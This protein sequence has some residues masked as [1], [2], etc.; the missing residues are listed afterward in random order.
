[1]S[2]YLSRLILDPRSRQVQSELVKP[3]Q[4]HRTLWRAFPNAEA[5]GEG[6][7]R[8]LFRVDQDDRVDL[9][10]VLVQSVRKP[11]WSFFGSIK[12]YLA[13][14]L[15]GVENP[16]VK[17]FSPQ[18]DAGRRLVFRLRANPTVKRDGKRLG[19][20]KEEDQIRWLERKGEVGGF[21]VLSARVTSENFA[22]D[23][24]TDNGGLRPLSFFSAR[25]DGL[26]AVTDPDRFL[27][28]IVTGIG[29]AKGFG[30]GLLSLAR[31]R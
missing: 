4:M 19:L 29:S 15:D 23:H 7:G 5:Q 6:V 31:A 8:V 13:R 30:F 10:M 27:Q 9:P 21:R 12:G 24:K 14:D 25:F 2:L 16:A 17:S 28:S 22:R 18:I 11:D 1:M 20:I 26:L 3:F